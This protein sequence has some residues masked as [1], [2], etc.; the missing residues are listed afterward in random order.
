M[1]TS[2]YEDILSYASFDLPM[3]ETLENI[4]AKEMNLMLHDLSDNCDFSIVDVDAVAAELGGAQH[5][6]DGIHHSAAMQAVLRSEIFHVLN[7]Q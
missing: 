2:G 5:L 7:S 6:P 3:R 1:S 4:A